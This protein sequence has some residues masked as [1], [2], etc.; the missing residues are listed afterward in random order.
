MDLAPVDEMRDKDFFTVNK[1]VFELVIDEDR[2][3]LSHTC[4][5][6]AYT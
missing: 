3:R 1:D 5:G 2:V 4:F 6:L